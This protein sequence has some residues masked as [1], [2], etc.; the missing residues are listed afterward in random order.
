MRVR[1]WMNPHPVTVSPDT[2]AV[3]AARLLACHGCRYLPV[4]DD[5]R[6]VGIV[7]AGDLQGRDSLPVSS[8]MSGPVVVA[9]TDESVSTA[10]HRMLDRQ[11]EALP[12]V[13]RGR[14]VGMLTLAHCAR[15]FLAADLAEA[16]P[17]D[18]P[19]ELKV[20][21]SLDPV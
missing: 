9:R 7:S 8:V 15:G 16:D 21:F 17:S 20:A 1:E 18:A 11:L 3:N 6:V 14:F 4:V 19:D 2:A 5:D 13:E 12:V 10:A